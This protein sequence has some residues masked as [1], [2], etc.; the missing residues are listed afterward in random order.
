MTTTNAVPARHW[1]QVNSKQVEVTAW[2]PSNTRPVH[3]GEY[4]VMS[5]RAGRG[6]LVGRAYRYWDGS[7]WRSWQGG[8][9]SIF[10]Q[11]LGHQWRGLVKQAGTT[12]TSKE[13][14]DGC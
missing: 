1:A 11:Y 9:V 3:I 13:T 2:L 7:C 6:R 12:T 10:G 5:T 14:A 4:Q 8:P